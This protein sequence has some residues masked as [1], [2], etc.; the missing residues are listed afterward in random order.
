MRSFRFLSE[1]KNFYPQRRSVASSAGT[2]ELAAFRFFFHFGNFFVSAVSGRANLFEFRR[3]RFQFVIGMFFQVDQFDLKAGPV[4]AQMT[5]IRMATTKAQ[6]DPKTEEVFRAKTPNASR[7]RQKKLLL[8]FSGFSVAGFFVFVTMAFYVRAELRCRA[9]KI[10]KMHLAADALHLNFDD[11]WPAGTMAGATRD[12]KNWGPRLRFSAPVSVVEDFYREIATQLPPF[13]LYGSGDFHHLTALWVRRFA[14][15]FVLVS[16]DNHPDWDIRPPRWACGGWVNRA[17]ELPQLRKVSVWGCGN[18]ECW[19]PAQFFG[20]R[21]AE[22]EG[23]LEIRAWGDNRPNRRGAIFL[24][25][26]RKDFERF[27]RQLDGVDVYVTIDIDCLRASD[28]ITNW[29][30]GK[31]ATEDV[32][33][34]LEKLRAATRIVGGD[35]CGAFSPP[36]YA[37]RKQR[38]VAEWDHPKLATENLEEAQRVNST[39]LEKLWPILTEGNKHQSGG[40]EQR[41]NR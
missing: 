41:T 20:N 28:S 27:V 31:F 11:A 13:L 32:A 34:A 36:K 12:L 23:R 9:H 1:R 8:P 17:L 4:S 16:F 25:S 24:A 7:T 39:A 30:N 33:W 40:N 15:P 35:L 19:W 6:A 29:E 2:S 37:R 5:M 26:W 21:R 14:E 3:D 10:T 38:F 18:F 22:A